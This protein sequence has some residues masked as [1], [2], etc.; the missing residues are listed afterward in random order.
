MKDHRAP[1]GAAPRA[2]SVSGPT[3]SPS[4]NILRRCLL[5]DGLAL[6]VMALLAGIFSDLHGVLSVVLGTVLVMV[7]FGLSLLAAHLF[8]RRRPQALISIF[9]MSYF[10][11]VLGFAAVLFAVGTPD[12]LDKPW[13]LG[14]AV[15]AVLFWQGVE[16][17]TFSQ[18]RFLRFD[19]PATAQRPRPGAGTGEPGVNDDARSA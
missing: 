15:A 5:V 16:V 14:S 17:W 7:F 9:F 18:Q 1:N 6:L 2:L 13:F 10:V 19:E 12:W 11:K 8:G 4:A 3:P